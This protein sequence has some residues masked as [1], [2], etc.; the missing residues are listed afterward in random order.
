MSLIFKQLAGAIPLALRFERTSD[1][2]LR[3]TP[4]GFWCDIPVR[5]AI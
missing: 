3:L 5:E 2:K 1:A 4:T